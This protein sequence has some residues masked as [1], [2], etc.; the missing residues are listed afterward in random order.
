MTSD[1]TNGTAENS[2]EGINLFDNS[3]VK[4]AV[5]YRWLIFVIF[6][7]SIL[8]SLNTATKSVDIYS[9]TASLRIDYE[10]SIATQ[11]IGLWGG[12]FP[13][14]SYH[15]NPI[16][17]RIALLSSRVVAEGVVRKLNRNFTYSLVGFEKPKDVRIEIFRM[18]EILQTDTFSIKIDKDGKGEIDFLSS[19][20]MK[21]SESFSIGDTLDIG[22]AYF[23][24]NAVKGDTGTV[25]V[26]IVPVNMMAD[27]VRNMVSISNLEETNILL[28]TVRH[29]N[30][31]EARLVANAFARAMVEF[32]V[33]R[34]R[35]TAKNVREFI[36]R[37]LLITNSSLEDAE[38]NLKRLQEE[39]GWLTAQTEKTRVE[40][41]LSELIRLRVNTMIEL[42][43]LEQKLH[44]LRTQLE[45]GGAFDIYSS[46]QAIPELSSNPTLRSIQEQINGY[47]IQKS[48]LL[49]RYTENHPSVR[50]LD[51]VIE[52]LKKQIASQTQAMVEEYGSGPVDPVWSSL[53]KD[54]VMTEVDLA[55][56]RARYSAL[57]KTIYSIQS[58]LESLP[59]E[60]AEFERV[61][62]MVEV[63]KQTYTVLLQKLQE[64]KISEATQVGNISLIDS[65]MT[66]RRPMS[67][68]RKKN[69]IIAGFIGAVLGFSI[70]FLL[71]KLDT[72]LRDPEEVETALG[73]K[74]LGIIPAISE[75]D[76]KESTKSSGSQYSEALSV[77]NTL[78]THISPK[79]PISEAYRTI[80]TNISFGSLDRKTRSLTVA[81]AL[82]KEGKSTT[83][84]NIAVAFAQQNI[85][86]V[87]IDTDLRKPV[88]HSVFSIERTPGLI[89]YLFGMNSLE[90]V[91]KKTEVENLFL[92]PS[93]TIPPN[94]SEVIS[95][96]KMDSLIK[97]TL[98]DYGFVIFDSPPI[99]AVTDAAVLSKKTD[100]TV[101]V[102][103]SEKTDRDAAKTALKAL[104][105]IGAEVKGAIFNNVDISGRYGYGYYYRYYYQYHYGQEFEEKTSK[106]AGFR[107]KLKNFFL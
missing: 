70:A 45:G 28:V 85:K 50:R 58:E 13:G 101:L 81:S 37:Q 3:V 65:A 49:G 68:K 77:K 107:E 14:Y 32:D 83:A 103:R 19:A 88:L 86:T 40:Q 52:Y 20:G 10:M 47:E 21:I 92:I 74:L 30:P 18:S 91:L 73:I 100:G 84:S 16:S 31:E 24:L 2:G 9:A 64:A 60:I 1:N 90:D 62:R 7:V 104:K 66:P 61:Y 27:I 93:G 35:Q 17:D 59:K 67:S 43:V 12:V 42:R 106:K 71:E 51:S 76:A 53:V 82:P 48:E 98:S 6:I 102:I 69:I 56:S 94:P 22:P 78:I 55:S 44:S 63:E 97:E 79:S 89:E 38:K 41:H 75:N 25:F 80:R 11:N 46:S 4:A 23:S 36:E 57:E 95:S 15:V 8:V 105:N 54:Y 72:T 33:Q 39:Y 96:E 34:G 29:Y 87:L 5:R 99:L 26:R